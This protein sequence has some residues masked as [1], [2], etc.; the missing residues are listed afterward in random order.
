[1]KSYVIAPRYYA[2]FFMLGSGFLI[3]RTFALIAGGSLA[4]NT[5]WVSAL[6][7]LEMIADAACLFAS[8]KWWIRNNMAAARLPLQLCAA[9]VIMHAIRVLIFVIG[10]AGPWINFDV[11]PEER[12]I[13]YTRWTW[14]GVYIAGILSALSV[15]A[16]V[17]IWIVRK[18]P[19]RQI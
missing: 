15:I 14:E 9:M 18:R 1:M 11:R 8:I 12:A 5:T 13:H 6:L 2:S 17:I 3:Y 4:I 19:R 16:V 10:R 7:F